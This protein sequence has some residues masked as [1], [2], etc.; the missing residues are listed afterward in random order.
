MQ[1]CIEFAARA[2]ANGLVGRRIH[3]PVPM[4]D[5]VP[6]LILLALVML[7]ISSVTMPSK[8][9]CGLKAGAKYRVKRPFVSPN[10]QRFEEGEVLVFKRERRYLPGEPCPASECVPEH[11]Y[12]V[13]GIP[14]TKDEKAISGYDETTAR[15]SPRWADPDKWIRYF[16]EVS[17]P[18]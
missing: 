1:E 8:K 9:S 10:G 13:F 3:T 12:W 18:V 7:V 5:F 11:D 16:D 6:I 15:E 17:D 2:P 4:Q 14:G